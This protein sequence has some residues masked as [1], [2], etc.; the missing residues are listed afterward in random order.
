M[1]MNNSEIIGEALN[2]AAFNV[3]IKEII[4][5]NLLRIILIYFDSLKFYLKKRFKAK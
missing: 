2:D 1:T 5:R 3:S 4:F